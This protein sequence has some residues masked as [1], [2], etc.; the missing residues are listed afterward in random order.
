MKNPLGQVKFVSLFKVTALNL[1]VIVM[2]PEIN[3]IQAR[4]FLLFKGL[5]GVFRDTL[6]ISGT[7]KASPMKLCTVIVLLNTY[8]NTKK[9]L[10]KYDL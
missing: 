2:K 4:L 8:Q 10:Q 3:P 6:K 1:H 9:N 7:S 5:R